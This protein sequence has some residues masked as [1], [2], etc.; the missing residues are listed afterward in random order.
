M[1]MQASRPL[2]PDSQRNPTNTISHAIDTIFGYFMILTFNNSENI[3]LTYFLFRI[4]STQIY[5]TVQVKCIENDCFPKWQ[6]FVQNSNATD[7][8]PQNDNQYSTTRWS[9]ICQLYAQTRTKPKCPD[10]RG[11]TVH[12]SVPWVH[13]QIIRKCD[14]KLES[15]LPHF[16]HPPTWWR[17]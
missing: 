8:F 9:K 17:L 6:F 15:V 13:V 5:I 10:E 3:S 4:L 1:D 12:R 14:L 16:R 11:S 2:N 7:H